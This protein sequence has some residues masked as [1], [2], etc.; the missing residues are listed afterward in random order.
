M[1]VLRLVVMGHNGNTSE[2]TEELKDNYN[3]GEIPT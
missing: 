3:L 1:K 2:F